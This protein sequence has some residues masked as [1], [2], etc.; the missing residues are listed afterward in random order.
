MRN[1]TLKTNRNAPGEETSPR[2]ASFFALLRNIQQ[3]NKE[4]VGRDSKVKNEPIRL[5]CNPSL[6]YPAT[7]LAEVK[8]DEH[9]LQRIDVNFFG[10]F[11]PSGTLPL[12]YTQ[13]I[14]DRQRSKDHTL[15]DFL[16]AFNHRWLS[17]FY[18]AWE[19]NHF[20]TAFQTHSQIGETDP[21]T[22][23]FRALTGIGTKGT[24]SRLRA[25][26]KALLH[27]AGYF[28]DTKRRSESLASIL[29][30]WF[31]IQVKIEQFTGQWIA[32]EREDQTRLQA[33]IL[34]SSANNRLGINAVAGSRVW[35]VESRIRICVGPLTW[36]QFAEFLPS[37]SKLFELFSLV[38]AY[39]GS[40]FDVDVQL[41]LSRHEVP[42]T[43][44]SPEGVSP[45][46]DEGGFAAT[47]PH[48]APISGVGAAETHS[49]PRL[50]W[51]TWLG[52]WNR[53]SDAND[54][55]FELNDQQT[56]HDLAGAA[57]RD[58]G[59]GVR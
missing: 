26:D 49:Q 10:L 31:R 25:D 36:N 8:K 55:T 40:Q 18:R 21:L 53:A 7:E 27:F 6:S 2:R 15:S 39:V 1:G 3:D 44:L 29:E 58:A 48:A 52:S 23:I 24:Q 9:G 54:A 46:S 41:I 38:R 59:S 50:G 13:L 47:Q 12:H 4:L 51:N 45:A 20:A 33:T 37:G 42:Q 56:V 17:L 30:S 35:N 5:G 32:I 11:G 22:L 14:L 34:G 57:M 16:D 43:K 19:K 28:S